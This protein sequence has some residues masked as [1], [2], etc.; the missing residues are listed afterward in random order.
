[1]KDCISVWSELSLQTFHQASLSQL[2]LSMLVKHLHTVTIWCIFIGLCHHR[3]VKHRLRQI[4]KVNIQKLY[5]SVLKRVRLLK[6]SWK[7]SL[8]MFPKEFFTFT[9]TSVVVFKNI[10]G[11]NLSS[12]SAHEKT[13]QGFSSMHHFKHFWFSYLPIPLCH[14]YLSPCILYF[15]MGFPYRWLLGHTFVRQTRLFSYMIQSSTAKL[16]VL[17]FFHF[18]TVHCTRWQFC[19]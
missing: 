11:T 9:S 6:L 1:M 18:S 16:H 3:P 8:G 7:Q 4:D 13:T 14:F 19:N 12:F 5:F 17:P 15:K 2:G 10:E